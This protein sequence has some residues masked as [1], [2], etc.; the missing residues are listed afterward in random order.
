MS[1]QQNERIL[2][3]GGTIVT[4]DPKVAN[5][6]T[7][8]VLV[9]GTR[10]AAVGGNLQSD[11]AQVIDATGRIVMPGFVDAHHHMWLGVMRRMMPDVDDLFA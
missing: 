3:K 1:K 6:A 4:M 11:D 9:E 10:I 7:G 8:D 5:L 2:F